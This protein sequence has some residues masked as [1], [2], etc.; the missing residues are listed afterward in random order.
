MIKKTL[1]KTL[2][3]ATM[4]MTIA[5]LVA[6][7]LSGSWKIAFAIGLLEPCF[8]TIAYFFH[9]R[10]WHR[11]EKRGHMKDYHNSV[12]DSASPATKTVENILKHKH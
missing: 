9:E 8:Q 10:A 7:F 2:S 4:H 3:Y 6:Y 1:L 12:I 5:I 11:I